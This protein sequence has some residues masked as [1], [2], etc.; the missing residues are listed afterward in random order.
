MYQPD[1]S[2]LTVFTLP[3]CSGCDQT[4]NFLRRQLDDG[5]DAHVETVPLAETPEALTYVKQ[6][7]GHTAAPVVVTGPRNWS[8]YRPDLLREA[9]AE[10]SD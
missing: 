10:L 2:K 1:L 4:V 3:N 8:G 5:F 6:E 9:V 7:L